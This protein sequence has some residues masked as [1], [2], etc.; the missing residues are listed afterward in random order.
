MHAYSLDFSS[1]LQD[2]LLSGAFSDLNELD[3]PDPSDPWSSIVHDDLDHT[4][5]VRSRAVV[6][7]V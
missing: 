4:T 5:F 1:K 7:N 2:H 6:F 3:L